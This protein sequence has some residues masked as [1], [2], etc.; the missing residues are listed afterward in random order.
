M[1][2]VIHRYIAIR[3]ETLLPENCKLQSGRTLD[4]LGHLGVIPGLGESV[5]VFT[6]GTGN[7]SFQLCFVTFIMDIL[8]E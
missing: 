3:I 5:L 4:N 6:C 7:P 2:I 1:L 8:Y